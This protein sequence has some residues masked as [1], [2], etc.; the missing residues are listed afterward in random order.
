MSHRRYVLIGVDAQIGDR[1]A[2]GDRGKHVDLGADVEANEIVRT[3]QR[4][5]RLFGVGNLNGIPSS[6]NPAERIDSLPDNDN[7][8]IS[9]DDRLE[10]LYGLIESGAIPAP[11]ARRVTIKCLAG[12]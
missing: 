7:A 6:D 3:D 8:L 4:H 5:R 12:F 11:G 2:A 1:P 10:V 9:V